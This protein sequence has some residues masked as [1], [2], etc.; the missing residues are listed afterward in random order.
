MLYRIKE[1]WED[2][3]AQNELRISELVACTPAAHAALWQFCLNIDLV[4]AVTCY[5]APDEPLRWMLADPRR[6]TV[7]SCSDN[8][9]VRVI[10]IPA[11]LSERRYRAEDRLV[12]G[13][14][15]SFLP[16]NSRAYV[17]DGSPVGATCRP[18]D[19]EPDLELES[20]DLGAV[21][22]GGVR[23]STLCRAGRVRECRAGALRR[24]DDLFAADRDPLCITGF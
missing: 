1:N 11:A 3:F 13:V 19:A 21:Y 4:T 12:L 8:L 14:Q 24:A 10:D 22:L 7:K 17:L 18:T 23:F 5:G 20:A 6:L 16:E 2:G 9:W 15:D